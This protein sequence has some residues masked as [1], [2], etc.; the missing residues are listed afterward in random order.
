VFNE[1]LPRF[2]VY[3]G[4]D[5]GGLWKGVLIEDQVCD[6]APLLAVAESGRIE[7]AGGE[8]LALRLYRGELHRS[9]AKG[10]TVARFDEGTFLVGVQD[11]VSRRNR[12]SQD[13]GQLTSNVLRARIE[14]MK[15]AGKAHEERRL[16]FELVRRSAVPL[17]CLVFTLLAVPLAVATRGARGSAYLITLASFVAFY[18]LSR[19]AITLADNGLN[20]WIAGFLPNAVILAIGISYTRE[21]LRR[22]VGK[23]A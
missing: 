2:T 14:D 22:G 17:A 19:F 5:E 1:S 11:P 7:D 8:A 18:V 10:E 9:E 15:R 6:G 23:P 12:F 3:V 13:Y 20:A 16:R 4:S 21:L